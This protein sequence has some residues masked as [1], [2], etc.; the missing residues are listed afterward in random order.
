MPILVDSNVILDVVTQDPTWEPWSSSAL[1]QNA[2]HGSLVN[3]IIYSELC[4]N[5]NSVQEVDAVLA[6]LKIGYVERPREALYL[7]AKAHLSYRRRGGT[8]K[9]GLPDFFVGAHAQASG[10][11]ILTRDK[12]RYQTYFPAALL[13]AP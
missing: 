13:I 2:G 6:S 3:P 4:G 10:L 11:S 8:R 9:I 5:A 1:A 7:A 12:G